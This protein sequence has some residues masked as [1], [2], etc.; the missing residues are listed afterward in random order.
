MGNRGRLIAPGGLD[1][2]LPGEAADETGAAVG[3]AE[4][5]PLADLA[6]R[7]GLRPTSERPLLVAYLRKV[8]ERRHFIVAYATARNVSRPQVLGVPPGTVFRTL[9]A[10]EFLRYVS[11]LRPHGTIRVN[12]R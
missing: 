8:W 6:A 7:Y 2:E 3:G 5:E 12:F 10:T 4:G 9:C 1:D 11:R